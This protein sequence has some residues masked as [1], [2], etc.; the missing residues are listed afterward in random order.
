MRYLVKKELSFDSAHRLV[1]GYQGKCAHVHGHTWR[2]RFEIAADK[3]DRFGFVRD[4]ADFKVMKAWIDEHLDHATLVSTNDQAL[5]RF[6][7]EQNQRMFVTPENPTSENLAK[8][9]FDVATLHHLPV[10]AVEIC[11]TCTSEARYEP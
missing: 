11:E 10:T 5:R 7:H 6:L 3:L 1:Q 2:V 9:L 8:I 4:Y